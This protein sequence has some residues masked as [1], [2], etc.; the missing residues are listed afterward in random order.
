MRPR[1]AS[2]RRLATRLA[3][4][5]LWASLASAATA[6]PVADFYAGR[7]VRVLVGFGPGGG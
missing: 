7:T 1:G 5:V 2:R 4:A 3:A 6:D